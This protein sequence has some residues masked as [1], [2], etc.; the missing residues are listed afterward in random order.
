MTIQSENIKSLERAGENREHGKR[1][2]A[3]PVHVIHRGLSMLT[4]QLQQRLGLQIRLK[5]TGSLRSAQGSL[6]LQV[7]LA[8]WSRLSFLTSMPYA[9]YPSPETQLAHSEKSPSTD[10]DLPW[11][12]RQVEPQVQR[13]SRSQVVAPRRPLTLQRARAHWRGQA[14]RGAPRKPGGRPGSAVAP[15]ALTTHGPAPRLRRSAEHRR[16]ARRGRDQRGGTSPGPAPPRGGALIS[17]HCPIAFGRG[18]AEEGG[19]LRGSWSLQSEEAP[20]CRC[21]AWCNGTWTP[22]KSSAAGK[23]PA[24]ERSRALEPWSVGRLWRE[25]PSLTRIE[26]GSTTPVL[27]AWQRRRAW[28]PQGAPAAGGNC[29]PKEGRLESSGHLPSPPSPSAP[30]SQGPSSQG[31]SSQ[32]PHQR[33]WSPL[34]HPESPG[35]CSKLRANG[36]FWGPE[37]PESE[38]PFPE[39]LPFGVA[40]AEVAS[41][42]V[43]WA[44]WD[45]GRARMNHLCGA[46][47]SQQATSIPLCIFAPSLFSSTWLAWRQKA[48]SE[49]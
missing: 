4:G 33:P 43:T 22:P 46:E 13:G 23:V 35:T 8:P 39:R 14:P 41:A 19:W 10:P 17:P 24:W 1:Q 5:K 32:G 9:Q 29:R 3:G 36:R 20:G 38:R 34:P 48:G 28:L 27:G 2:Q 15:S 12:K 44:L 40:P 18:R 49:I 11:A 37:A 45:S 47:A 16:P 30:S 7:P 42:A 21:G 31:P 6:G 26:T 25:M